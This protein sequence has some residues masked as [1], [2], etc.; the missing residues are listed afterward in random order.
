[1]NLALGLSGL[2]VSLRTEPDFSPMARSFLSAEGI[3]ARSVKSSAY[4]RAATK[5][6]NPHQTATTP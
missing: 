4:A 5:I 1:M 3:G 2:N 6:S